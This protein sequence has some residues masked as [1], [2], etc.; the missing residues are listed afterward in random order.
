MKKLI[1]LVLILTLFYGCVKEETDSSFLQGQWVLESVVCYC[2]F[3]PEA[4]F[5]KHYIWFFPDEGMMVAN[6]NGAPLTFK[7]PGAGYQYDIRDSTLSFKDSSKKYTLE[8]TEDRLT[9][10]YIDH[11]QIADDEISYHFVKGLSNSTCLDP[12][13]V[14]M[15]ICTKEYRP[16][17]G[18]DGITY[19]NTCEAEASGIQSWNEGSCN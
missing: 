19:G 5:S 10:R 12:S 17:C 6:G 13:K 4:D 1:V 7:E 11:P 15:S 18:C 16:V 3:W 14:K 2:Y 9:I 8:A